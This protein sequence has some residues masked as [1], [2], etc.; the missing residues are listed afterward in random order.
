M[1]S[2]KFLIIGLVALT[3]LVITVLIA[4]VVFLT[5]SSREQQARLDKALNELSAEKDNSNMQEDTPT[6]TDPVSSEWSVESVSENEMNTNYSVNI[7]YPKL[8]NSGN[9]ETESDVNNY[10]KT[11]VNTLR[12]E[13]EFIDSESAS[14]KPYINLNYKV[15]FLNQNF[16]S[17]LISGSQYLGGVHPGSIFVPINYDLRS[18]QVVNISYI[19]NPASSYLETLS[20]QSADFISSNLGVPLSDPQLIAGT[21][22][23]DDNF[24]KFYFSGDSTIETFSIVFDEYEVAPYAA[25]PQTVDVNVSELTS[26]FNSEF[27]SLL[28]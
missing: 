16:V 27:T 13:V 21:A 9:P 28:D 3:C 26:L 2:K 7:I 23:S 20:T 22:E 6:T 25:G 11:A 8:R 14:A 5:L 19:F 10:I 17:I 4:A 24:S 12:E 15:K 1:S 18:N